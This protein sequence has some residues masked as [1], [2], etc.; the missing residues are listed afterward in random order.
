MEFK[1]KRTES[2]VRFLNWFDFLEEKIETPKASDKVLVFVTFNL[3]LEAKK[4]LT[5]LETQKTEFDILVVDNH[6]EVKCWEQLK[7]ENQKINLIRTADNIGG[8]GGYA[9]A[10]EWCLQREYEFIL[11]TEDDAFPQQHNLVDEMFCNATRDSYVTITY[12]NEGCS[13]FSFHFSIYPLNL[14]KEIG[15]PDPTF[16]MIQDDLEFLKRQKIGN[17]SLNIIENNLKNLS[18]T[19]PTYKVKKNIWTEYFDVRNGLFVDERYSNFIRQILNFSI[20]IPYCWSRVF[21]DFN[22]SSIK[23]IHYA[24]IDYLLNQKSYSHNGKR[25]TQV[26]NF[27][28]DL[29]KMSNTPNLMTMNDIL[30]LKFTINFSSYLKKKSHIKTRFHQLLKSFISTPKL[31]VAGNYLTLSHPLFMLSDEIIF[32]ESIV[33]INNEEKFVTAKWVNIKSFRKLRLLFTVILSFSNIV[34]V[35]PLIVIKRFV[36]NFFKFIFR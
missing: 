21:Y 3:V 12:K 28:L 36:Y 13:S 29:L 8:S 23:S 1:I 25:R 9:V 34:L 11:V 14:I 20:K 6:S 2:S 10:L 22:F 30:N 32:V 26:K 18:Y 17:K 19:H 15:V 33:E 27:K 4:L 16:F 7:L 5:F 24:L 35:I 31:V